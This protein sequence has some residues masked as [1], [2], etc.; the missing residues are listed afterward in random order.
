MLP[1]AAL[2][3]ANDI[4]KMGSENSNHIADAAMPRGDQD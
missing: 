3:G 4:L 1:H 2:P